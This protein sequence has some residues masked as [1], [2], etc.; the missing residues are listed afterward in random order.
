MAP[1][2]ARDVNY[3]LIINVYLHSLF[4]YTASTY[5]GLCLKGSNSKAQILLSGELSD[6]YAWESIILVCIF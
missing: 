1:S 6:N 2:M 5:H 3:M 4:K